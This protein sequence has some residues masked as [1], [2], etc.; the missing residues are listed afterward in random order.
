M[1]LVHFRVDLVLDGTLTRLEDPDLGSLTAAQR[2]AMAEEID[3][4]VIIDA[5]PPLEVA[6]DLTAVANDLCFAGPQAVLADPYGCY[7]YRATQATRHTVMIPLATQIRIFGEQTPVVT[8]D[9]DQLLPELYRCGMRI[10]DLLERAGEPTEAAVTLDD[11]RAAAHQ[12]RTRLS[13][14]GVDV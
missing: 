11:L 12:L 5:D 8:A 1:S 4:A 2:E 6:D 9:I 3:G 10:I 13:A 7:L 14:R